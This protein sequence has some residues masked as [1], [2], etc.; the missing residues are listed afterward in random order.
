MNKHINKIRKAVLEYLDNAEVQ[1]VTK[2]SLKAKYENGELARIDYE[3]NLNEIENQAIDKGGVIDAIGKVAKEYQEGLGE[4]A[5]LKAGDL[6]DDLKLFNTP[7]RLNEADYKALEEKNQSSYSMLRA[8]KEHA[9]KND[10]FYSSSHSVDREEK[11]NSFNEFAKV[12]T[13]IAETMHGSGQRNYLGTLWTYEDKF[14]D[15]Y[16]DASQNIKTDEQ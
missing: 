9:E 2:S 5:V 4:W 13:N 15:L 12:A 11:L 6:T 14:N 16:A 7:I 10:V 1:E 3:R 8:I